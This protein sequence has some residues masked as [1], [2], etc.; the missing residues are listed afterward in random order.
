MEKLADWLAGQSRHRGAKQ[1]YIAN[2]LIEIVGDAAVCESYYF[3]YI[4]FIGDPEFG[5]RRTPRQ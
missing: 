2:Q 5:G 3:C 4:E 1:H